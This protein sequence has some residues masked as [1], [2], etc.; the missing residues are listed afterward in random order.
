[1]NEVV[2]PVPA[3]ALPTRS[4]LN[5]RSP[6]GARA[7]RPRDVAYVVEIPN[8]TTHNRT[9]KL[10]VVT[11]D[12]WLRGWDVNKSVRLV[13]TGHVIEATVKGIMDFGTATPEGSVPNLLLAHWRAE[14][15]KR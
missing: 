3:P 2:P 11:C 10:L 1:V 6:R 9:K 7:F 13:T 12:S 8:S 5:P 14:N 15:P 4:V